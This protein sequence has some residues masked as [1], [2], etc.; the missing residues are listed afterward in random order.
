MRVVFRVV[1]GDSGQSGVDVGAAKFLGGD[2]LTGRGLH[3]RRA[4]EENRPGALDD[5]RLVRHRGH[6]R[7]AR[8]ARSHHDGDLREAGGRHARL[9]E[10]DAAEVLA[11]RKDVCLERQERAAGVYQVH[12]RQVVLERD[13]LCP[14]VLLD[15]ERVVRA[16]L[17]RRVVGDDHD[18][19]S[20]DAGNPRHEA[21]A[22]RVVLV[23]LEGGKRRELEERRAR[24]DQAIETFADR[25]LALRAVPLEVRGA[26][27]LA[28]R[29][30]AAAKVRDEPRHAGLVLA[31]R[32]ALRRHV[33]REPIHART[34]SRSS[35]S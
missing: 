17:D 16:A 18:L 26:A 12:A 32:R 21:G 30:Q 25:Q 35:R 28:R 27:A 33:G 19:A 3:E 20:R 29:G 14:Q 9:V 6:V 24:V 8:R 31:E 13:L 34:T 5:D 7:A 10:E 22:G 2:F 4:A 15:G 11:I 1:V 23:H